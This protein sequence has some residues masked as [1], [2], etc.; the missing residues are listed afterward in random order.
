MHAPQCMVHLPA[1][2]G[3]RLKPSFC[4]CTGLGTSTHWIGSC[5]STSGAI[6]CTSMSWG[7]RTP[8]RWASCSPR[9]T[10]PSIESPLPRERPSPECS[11]CALLSAHDRLKR[12][13]NCMQENKADTLS[14]LECKPAELIALSLQDGLLLHVGM[15]QSINGTPSFLHRTVSLYTQPG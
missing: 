4:F 1:H 7:T 10:R 9:S 8:L 14:W 13:P 6:S 5:S 3:I 15:V 2:E 12:M 11:R